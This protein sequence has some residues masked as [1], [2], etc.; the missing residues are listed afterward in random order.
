[1]AAVLCVSE[2]SLVVDVSQ[3]TMFVIACKTLGCRLPTRAAQI[4]ARRAPGAL[5]V[6][7]AAVTL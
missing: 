5:L 1:M 4:E 7:S 2:P 6:C 3:S